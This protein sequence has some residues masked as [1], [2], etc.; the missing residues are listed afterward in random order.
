MSEPTTAPPP[1][2]AQPATGEPEAKPTETVEFWKAQARANEA[3]AKENATKAKDYDSYVESQKSEQQRLADQVAAGQR[4]IETARAE[5]LRYRIAA[6]HGLGEDDF[7]LLGVGTEEQ[8]EARAS[9][10][11]ALA[12]ASAAPPSTGPKPDPHQGRPPAPPSGA[13]AGLAEARRRFGPPQPAAPSPT[14]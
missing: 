5:A 2:G 1:A 6:K 3:R 9:R 7:D 13:D 12:K 8:L 14:S 11:A 10:I 4:E